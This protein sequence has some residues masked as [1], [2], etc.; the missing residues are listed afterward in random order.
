MHIAH[1]TKGARE[2]R[3]A[4]VGV[5]AGKKNVGPHRWSGGGEGDDRHIDRREG[6]DGCALP[7]TVGG[8]LELLG[9]D[10]EQ[11]RGG[12]LGGNHR[13]LEGGG[14]GFSREEGSPRRRRA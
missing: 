5:V 10:R 7:Q 1:G 14:L 12:K 4:A 11:Q 13:M 3:D 2:L 6:F 9:L 8:G